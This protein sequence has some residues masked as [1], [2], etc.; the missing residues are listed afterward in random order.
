[1]PCKKCGKLFLEGE[2]RYENSGES[3]LCYPCAEKGQLAAVWCLLFIF[4][5]AGLFAL[6]TSYLLTYK[7]SWSEQYKQRIHKENFDRDFA[8]AL[9]QNK[10]LT[11]Y[12]E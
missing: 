7:C 1:M 2:V 9:R 11:S 6:G 10:S 4:I 3:P 12:T 8:L 5:I